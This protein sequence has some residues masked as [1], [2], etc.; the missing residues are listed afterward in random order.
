MTTP[1][2][3]IEK[4]LA[5]LTPDQQDYLV[6]TMEFY[7]SLLRDLGKPGVAKLLVNLQE[8]IELGSVAILGFEV[9]RAPLPVQK[10][11]EEGS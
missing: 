1:L 8:T 9:D 2:Q 5:Q 11:A 10:A 6:H 3:H 7:T 4:C